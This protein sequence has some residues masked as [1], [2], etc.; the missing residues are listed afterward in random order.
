M[1]GL[2]YKR[3]TFARIPNNNHIGIR[4][5]TAESGCP[6]LGSD[7][8]LGKGLTNVFGSYLL[9]T[10]ISKIVNFNLACMDHSH[11][12]TILAKMTISW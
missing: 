6:G 12:T 8:G 11:T 7:L 3:A 10:E 2:I 1:R 4:R 5:A 9:L